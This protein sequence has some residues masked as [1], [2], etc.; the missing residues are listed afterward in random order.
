MLNANRNTM[1]PTVQKII[2][3]TRDLKRTGKSIAFMW[4]KG[5]IGI[6]PNE[7]AGELAKRAVT[8]RMLCH[9]NLN[10]RDFLKIE[11]DIEWQNYGKRAVYTPYIHNCRCIQENQCQTLLITLHFIVV[12]YLTYM[13]NK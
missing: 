4:I 6:I 13:R 5:H 2:D 1:H 10:W 11:I 12:K 9:V 8:V 3:R 7:I